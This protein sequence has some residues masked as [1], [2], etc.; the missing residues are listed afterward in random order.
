MAAPRSIY[1]LGMRRPRRSPRPTGRPGVFIG[2]PSLT[3]GGAHQ[4][5]GEAI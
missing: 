1:S 4:W 3:G 5:S 2:G